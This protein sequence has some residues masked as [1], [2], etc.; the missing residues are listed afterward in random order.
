MKTFHSLNGNQINFSRQ[1]GG[2]PRVWCMYRSIS[3]F[4]HPK[5]DSFSP[6]YLVWFIVVVDDDVAVV[7]V[8]CCCCCCAA[9]VP[10]SSSSSHSPIRSPSNPLSS[11]F[12]AKSPS[13]YQPIT[14]SNQDSSSLDSYSL[15]LGGEGRW[16][17]YREG[18]GLGARKEMGL[19][20]GV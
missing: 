10:L 19:Q 5:I 1:T 7:V 14:S 6:N 15:A 12:A 11:M 8:Y 9:E 2:A 4:N 18:V 17:E 13:S 20:S 3:R 16:V